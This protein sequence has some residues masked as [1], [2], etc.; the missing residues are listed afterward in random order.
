M[1]TGNWSVGWLARGSFLCRCM[2]S[3]GLRALRV[4]APSCVY[5][6]AGGCSRQG[7]GAPLLMQ[8]P[9]QDEHGVSIEDVTVGGDGPGSPG[10]GRRRAPLRSESI[11]SMLGGMRDVVQP[12]LHAEEEVGVSLVHLK[13]EYPAPVRGGRPVRA[14]D[15]LT[16]QA[17]EA[18]SCISLCLFCVCSAVVLRGL[19][20]RSR[21]MQRLRLSALRAP[22]MGKG[23]IT[24][25]LGH[26]GAGKSTLLALLS[27]RTR[28]TSGDAIVSGFS[29]GVETHKVQ[30]RLG[31][32][33]QHD[34][35][36]DRLTVREHLELFAGVKGISGEL[37]KAEVEAALA[38][39][40]LAAQ[41]GIRA[42]KLSGGQ[43]RMTLV[44]MALIGDP[45][46]VL[47]DGEKRQKRP[48]THCMQRTAKS[49][50]RGGPKQQRVSRQLTGCTGPTRA[51]P[52]S[53]R[54]GW[55]RPPA[56]P[57][58]ASSS[59]PRAT[60][61]SCWRRTTWT[62]RTSSRTRSPCCPEGNSRCGVAGRR[63]AV[64][65]PLSFS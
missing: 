50:C 5:C 38:V 46:V 59:A 42:G 44:A 15:D 2:E 28:P 33:P 25:L 20:N 22:Q 24:A 39:T 37:A 27:G 65:N 60:A 13:K 41:E 7:Q 6:V 14:V 3:A 18:D 16:L 31:V 45:K 23:R 55:T 12:A 47:L 26:N 52:Q 10:G 40:G 54:R 51:H 57:C 17:R 30:R 4:P 62:R 43:M 56:A 63:G 53:P 1:E 58:G 36:W 61:P 48:E 11:F 19:L 9:E 32:C 34:A 35:L 8:A 21:K 49:P 64:A 29:V